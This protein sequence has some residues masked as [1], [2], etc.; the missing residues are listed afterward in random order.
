MGALSATKAWQIMTN[1][2]TVLAIEQMCAAQALDYRLPL[3]PGI[4]PRIAHQVVRKHIT[5]T[6]QDHLFKEDIEA[7]LAILRT[8]EVLRAVEGFLPPLK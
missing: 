5:H 1:L 3:K 6:E 2:E 4:G 7:S 8:Q